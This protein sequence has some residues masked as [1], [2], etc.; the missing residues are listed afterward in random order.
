M[1]KGKRKMNS[2]KSD[3]SSCAQGREAVPLPPPE[4]TIPMSGPAV[5]PPGFEDSWPQSSL[6]IKNCPVELHALYR[7]PLSSVTALSH[8]LTAAETEAWVSFAERVG[9][10]LVKHPAGRDVT[11]RDCGRLVVQDDTIAGALFE[12][13]KPFLS[14]TLQDS[15]GTTWDLD[16]CAG[17]LRLYKYGP[18][19][20]FGKHYDDSNDLDNERRTFFT[21]LLYLNGGEED[22]QES[23]DSSIGNHE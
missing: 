18:G 2:G 10:E 14:C 17:N 22:G 5:V 21:L 19:Q 8:L 7:G 11:H 1:P 9:F 13:M 4:I 23:G 6:Y 3:N 15:A 12:R 16:G 20:S